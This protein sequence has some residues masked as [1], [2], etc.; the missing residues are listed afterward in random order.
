M[1]CPVCFEHKNRFVWFACAHSVCVDCSAR[2]VE[3][4][5]T[6][7]PMCRERIK[8]PAAERVEH[9][10]PDHPLCNEQ[11]Q[12]VVCGIAALSMLLTCL[13]TTV[14]QHF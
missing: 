3:F 1:E 4:N 9:Q 10:A 7:C 5:H 6:E 12:F 13:G 8:A 14:T 2:M 11:V